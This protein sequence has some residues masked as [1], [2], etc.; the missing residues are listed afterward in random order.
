MNEYELKVLYYYA[1]IDWDLPENVYIDRSDFV[2]II[3]G[4]NVD[5]QNTYVRNHEDGFAGAAS[6]R[7]AFDKLTGEGTVTPNPEEPKEQMAQIVIPCTS[8]DKKFR[9]DFKIARNF[10][11]PC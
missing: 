3:N 6:A 5:K 9:I 7:K 4:D 11:F 2:V 1:A 8:I 10:G